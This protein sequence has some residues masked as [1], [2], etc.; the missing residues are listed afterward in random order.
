MQ[1]FLQ[2]LGK[3][4][5]VKRATRRFW[6][7]PWQ[8]NPNLLN[9]RHLKFACAYLNTQENSP[10]GTLFQR[11]QDRNVFC[12]IVRYSLKLRSLVQYFFV[13]GKSIFLHFPSIWNKF[14]EIVSRR[15]QVLFLSLTSPLKLYH[16]TSFLQYL[17]KY[18]FVRRATS[19]VQYFFVL[20]KSIFLH[21]PSIWNKFIE[22]VSGRFWKVPW[23]TNPNFAQV[24]F[25]SLTSPLKLYHRTSFLQYLGKYAFVRR[26]TRRFWKVLLQTNPYLLNKWPVKFAC[27]FLNTQESSPSGTPLKRL[28]DGIV[29]VSDFPTKFA[30]LY[31]FFAISR[32]IGVSAT[33]D[34]KVSESSIAN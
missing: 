18:A 8:T 19:L 11:L 15:A 10:F 24:L 13:L 30:S 4:A 9:K 3:Y 20:G 16:R 2:Y 1:C 31:D 33:C 21:F 26:A 34:R 25:L 29:S 27:A 22:I 14:I 7:V 12:I 6:K 32:Q 28:Q 17:G 5:F 23:Q